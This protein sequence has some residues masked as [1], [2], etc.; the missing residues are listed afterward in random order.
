MSVLVVLTAVSF[1]GVV[2][3]IGI[4]EEDFFMI[5]IVVIYGHRVVL[6]M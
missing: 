3:D 1:L 4:L 2:E 6:L 5:V